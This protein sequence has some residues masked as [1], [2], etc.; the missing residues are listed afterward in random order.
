MANKN[1]ESET[2]LRKDINSFKEKKGSRWEIMITPNYKH[3]K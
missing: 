3:S 1:S 2:D